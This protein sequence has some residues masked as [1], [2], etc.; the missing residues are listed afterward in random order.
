MADIIH[1][2]ACAHGSIIKILLVES[3]LHQN[4][5]NFEVW[6]DGVDSAN[7]FCQQIQFFAQLQSIGIMDLT[8]IQTPPPPPPPPQQ[9]PTQQN[10]A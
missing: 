7:K 1:G 10:P 2:L 9:N 5:L 8:E 3:L 4:W 6:Y